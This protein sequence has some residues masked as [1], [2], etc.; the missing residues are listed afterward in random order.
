MNRGMQ[1]MNGFKAQLEAFYSDESRNLG[2]SELNEL[3][4]WKITY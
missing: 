3:K 1:C 4:R 2:I